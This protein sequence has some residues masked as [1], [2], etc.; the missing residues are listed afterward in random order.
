MTNNKGFALV[1]VLWV[2]TLVTIMASS[3]TLTI[4]RET[5]ITSG[6]KETAEATALAEAGINYAILKLFGTDQEQSWQG[7]NSLYEIE[8]AGQKVRI[9]VADESGKISINYADAEQ[10]QQ[11]LAAI[12][13]DGELA[14]QL[15]DAILDWRDKNDL[16]RVYGA[17]K[18][19]YAAADKNYAPRNGLFAS[20]EEL[21][22]VMGMTP[23]IYQQLQGM[24][25]IYTKKAGINPTTAAREVLLTLP[26]VTAEM[27]DE[28]IEQRVVNER[29]Q[30]AITA[31]E[32]FKGSTQKSGIFRIIAEVMISKGIS[33][34][35]MVV[36]QKSTS[37]NG[38]PFKILK[39]AQD[40]QLPSLFLSAN[41]ARLIN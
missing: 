2:L 8:F 11:L 28:Y 1:L 21:Q 4:Q 35:V 7:F 34:Q 33:Q 9:K 29:N 24:I 20:I 19:Q 39:W 40:Y 18:D 16:H 36:V 27:V 25:S 41:D 38:L 5:A 14:E 6:L 30:E 12:N 26:E 31:P 15:V 23:L 3:F 37:Q 17:E 22:M 10:L 32:W 13:V